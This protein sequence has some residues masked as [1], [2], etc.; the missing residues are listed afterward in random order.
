MHPGELDSDSLGAL[1][2]DFGF[3][4]GP[5][6]T[7]DYLEVLRAHRYGHAVVVATA[8]PPVQQVPTQAD[9]IGSH[10]MVL[11]QMDEDGFALWCPF[12]SGASALLPRADRAWWRHWSAYALIFRLAFPART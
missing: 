7:D 11:E 12:E 10:T 3:S 6:R 4:T 8:H 5:T 2:Q 1:A 9:A